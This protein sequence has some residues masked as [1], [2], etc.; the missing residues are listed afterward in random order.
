LG[1]TPILGTFSGTDIVANVLT[2][3][4]GG[5]TITET[6]DV[7]DGNSCTSSGTFDI[8]ILDARLY[9]PDQGTFYD[10]PTALQDAWDNA[11]D[12]ETIVIPSGAYGAQTLTS[13]N[14]KNVII[15]WGASPGCISTGSI[16]LTG[17]TIEV[18]VDGTTA[19]TEYD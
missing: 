18:E 7:T 5:T 2:D 3:G 8:V 10:G 14:A 9:N 12:G 1:V 6:Y 4:T 13:T 16:D 11:M 19:C 17:S 15:T